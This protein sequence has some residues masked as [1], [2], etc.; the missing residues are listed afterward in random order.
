MPILMQKINNEKVSEMIDISQKQDILQENFDLDIQS[1]NE[2]N[3]ILI[4]SLRATYEGCKCNSPEIVQEGF[5]DVVESIVAWFKKWLAKFKEFI[6]TAFQ[7]LH[8]YLASTNKKIE[9]FVSRGGKM[10]DFT[11]QGYSYTIDGNSVNTCSVYDIINKT[12]SAIAAVA[13]SDSDLRVIVNQVIKEIASPDAM[14]YYRGEICGRGPTTAED[15]VPAIRRSFRGGMEEMRDIV[16]MSK[17]IREFAQNARKMKNVLVKVKKEKDDLE[18]QVKRI[19]DHTK[20]QSH[21]VHRFRETSA[22]EKQQD[23]VQ[24]IRKRTDSPDIYRYRENADEDVYRAITMIYNQSNNAIRS[25]HVMC[26]RFLNEKIKAI[27]EAISFY[28]WCISKANGEKVSTSIE[29]FDYTEEFEHVFSIA[30]EA[31]NN[32]LLN[33]GL[34]EL[35]VLGQCYE[36]QEIMFEAGG[37]EIK[38]KDNKPV[39]RRVRGL[40]GHVKE[41]IRKI[42][43]FLTETISKFSDAVS[44]ILKTDQEWLGDNNSFFEDL[45]SDILMNMTLTVVP[46][47]QRKTV[48]RMKQPKLPMSS[49]GTIQSI[50]DWIIDKLKG[51]KKEGNVYIREQDFYA[52]F[53]PDL[54]KYDKENPKRGALRYYRDGEPETITIKGGACKNAILGMRD[55]CRNYKMYSDSA[56]RTITEV[57]NMIADQENVL[58]RLETERSRINSSPLREMVETI[59]AMGMFSILEGSF[60]YNSEFFHMK[61]LDCTG[62]DYIP[63]LEGIGATADNSTNKVTGNTAAAPSQ[64]SGTKSVKDANAEKKDEPKPM[65]RDEKAQATARNDIESNEARQMIKAFQVCVTIATCKLTV[66]E[67]IH[68]SYMKILHGIV[69]GIKG[70]DEKAQKNEENRQYNQDQK[71]EDDRRFKEKLEK[72]DR[73]HKIAKKGRRG[74]WPNLKGVIFGD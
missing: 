57:K 72:M 32:D 30:N 42:V 14:N 53:F 66:C 70:R 64:S 68:K 10:E 29:A 43:N 45:P 40:F 25:V 60:L 20:H 63:L 13:N 8:M 41:F 15:F 21:I 33:E 16:V 58:R 6:T 5:S 3:D 56:K 54:Y 71:E 35:V 46:Y 52:H 23:I 2:Y 27:K 26:D 59:P 65:T 67:E 11:V 55:F 4:T 74:I 38:D 39:K 44:D 47:F 61:K 51:R 62:D 19:I 7:R 22:F 50:I 24:Q 1:S 49:G 36:A 69:D 18:A 34:N 17:T 37:V 9:V 73:A 12:E 28:N 31:Y 48:A